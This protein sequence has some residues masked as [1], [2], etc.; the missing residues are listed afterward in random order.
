[1]KEN[2]FLSD[3]FSC[4]GF[5]PLTTRRCRGEVALCALA[6]G[7]CLS[8]P[9][10]CQVRG[11]LHRLNAPQQRMNYTSQ[12]SKVG[13]RLSTSVLTPDGH[14]HRAYLP[15]RSPVTAFAAPS[16]IRGTMVK[17]MTS[18]AETQ[19]PGAVLFDD[20]GVAYLDTTAPGEDECVNALRARD[21]SA[22]I[23]WCAVALGAL[24]KGSPIESV[25]REGSPQTAF[26]RLAPLQHFVR[27]RAYHKSNVLPRPTQCLHL[28]RLDRFRGTAN[29]RDMG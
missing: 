24:A 15:N 13:D 29:L 12:T 22:C 3:F 25:S 7:K 2:V 18:P 19:R 21:P 11:M 9:R 23:F 16:Y 17:L 5:L 10:P 8:R 20:A 26:H 27:L 6:V 4:T 14:L 28:K 1:M